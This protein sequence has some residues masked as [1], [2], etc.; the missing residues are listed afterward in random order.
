M[1]NEKRVKHMVKL[2]S[3]EGKDGA[4]EIKIYS[5]FRKDY[6]GYN[7]LISLLWVTLGYLSL[8]G[9]ICLAFIEKILEKLSFSNAVM[10]IVAIAVGY[11]LA[12]LL[13]GVGVTRLYIKKHQNA[14]NH[15]KKYLRDLEILERMYEREEA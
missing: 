11:V 12:L 5:Y 9:M 10:L 14:K 2:A 1:L 13:Y 15:V 8:V 7:V 3:Y 4:D 6:V